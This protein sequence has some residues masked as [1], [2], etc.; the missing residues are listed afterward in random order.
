MSTVDYWIPPPERV[1]QKMS[2]EM[3]FSAKIPASLCVA[4]MIRR[5]LRVRRAQII[6]KTLPVSGW[7]FQECVWQ[8]LNLWQLAGR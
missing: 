6:S 7:R 3:P 2:Q 5:G 4:I 1:G 8:A